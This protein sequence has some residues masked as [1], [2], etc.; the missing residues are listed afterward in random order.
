MP[1]QPDRAVDGGF[2]RARIIET[3]AQEQE[4][5]EEDRR[6]TVSFAD[7][8][9]MDRYYG[10]V[11]LSQK[12]GAA[13]F[14]RVGMS[15][16]P[17]LNNHESFHGDGFLGL[18]E[19]AW[20]EKKVSYATILFS[21]NPR[22]VEVYDDMRRGL[23]MG[24][25]PGIYPR[26][27]KLVE[28]DDAGP[29]YEITKWELL[30]ISSALVPA[31]PTVGPVNAGVDSVES[32][33][34]RL[35]EEAKKHSRVTAQQVLGGQDGEDQT[36]EETQEEP[37][38]MSEEAE[39]QPEETP[40]EPEA[41]S[42]E[43]EA[44]AEEASQEGENDSET[45]GEQ[46]PEQT[47]VE[48]IIEMGRE[49]NAPAEAFQAIADGETPEQFR[50][51]LRSVRLSPSGRLEPTSEGE[52]AGEG[53]RTQVGPRF[54]LGNLVK[55]YAFPTDPQYKREVE[56]ELNIE[57]PT[58]LGRERRGGSFY[59][60]SQAMWDGRK[61]DMTEQFAV[62]TAAASA[63]SLIQTDV[64]HSNYIGLLIER[65][66]ILGRCRVLP[67]LTGDVD[68]PR[69]K[70]AAELGFVAEGAVQGNSDPTFDDVKL[71]PK[72]LSAQLNLTNLAL[73]QSAG[74]LERY[75]R[76]A[77]NAQFAAEINKV[78]LVGS[79]ATN[80]PT[81]VM[82]VSGINN[83]EFTKSGVPS[84]KDYVNMEKELIADLVPGSTIYAV[85]PELYAAAKVTEKAT[86]TA[87]FIYS[88]GQINDRTVFMT[89]HMESET[90][91][92]GDFS[93]VYVGFWTGMDMILDNIT[94]PGNMKIYAFQT[95]DVQ[96]AH[97]TS[98]CSL[99]EAA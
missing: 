47:A 31:N 41:S 78:I 10:K 45:E 93:E 95:W 70:S 92:M 13:D 88:G 37:E 17:M 66:A 43:E 8:T 5:G 69:I 34:I 22:A 80:T 23:R 14:S 38:A 56:F 54:S 11:I 75:V 60:P 6:L 26:E 72:I 40:E 30:E 68:I 24:I 44:E 55:H 9:A 85:D 73:H 71:R 84:W 94:S 52:E 98:F 15:S 79:G 76:E 62:S 64:D 32:H 25:S 19:K 82:K 97:A 28:E 7:E 3:F 83:V 35:V 21:N 89:T 67:G 86:N 51:R 12:P 57:P 42:E 29:T 81:G 96:V 58:D 50:E 18:V 2:F 46:V 16:V 87:E 61:R 53:T 63:G 77:L 39:E 20:V 65:A 91:L 1:Q 33:M 48:Q 4:G 99:T 36:V 59:V 27:V 90:G 74:F 49:Y